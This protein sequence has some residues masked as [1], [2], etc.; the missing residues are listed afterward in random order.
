M[1]IIPKVLYITPHNPSNLDGGAIGNR[2]ILFPLTSLYNEGKLDLRIITLG[3]G[4]SD[5]F[6]IRTC[7]KSRLRAII[8]R[9]FLLSNQLEL[10]ASNIIAFISKYKPDIVIMQS[11]R[12]GRISRSIR[13]IKDKSEKSKPF[14]VQHFDNFEKKASIFY[15][16]KLPVILRFLESLITSRSEYRCL[17]FADH[18]LFLHEQ[19]A[20]EVLDHYKIKLDYTIMPLY[21]AEMN[22]E[23]LKEYKQKDENDFKLLFTGSLNFYPNIEAAE[24]LLSLISEL[25]FI[26][27]A[28]TGKELCLIIMGSGARRNL[29]KKVDSLRGRFN[30]KLIINPQDNISK[31]VFYSSD[32]YASPIFSGPGMKTKVVEA[33]FFGLPIIASD[34]TLK[35]YEELYPYANSIIFPFRGMDKEEFLRVAK[36]AIRHI[37]LKD[38]RELVWEIKSIYKKHYN[39]DRFKNLLMKVIE[40]FDRR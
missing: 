31:E 27:S 8:A 26:V 29:E 5:S 24:Y 6:L 7:S 2:K 28:E 9:V 39:L 21:Y 25:S 12:L 13:Q 19:E 10:Y 15:K 4:Y 30:I 18:A 33:L 34:I 14:V 38:K 32:V 40:D 22:N 37:Y 36:K 3:D 17:K 35:G 23:L 20:K 16:R 11:S 1:K